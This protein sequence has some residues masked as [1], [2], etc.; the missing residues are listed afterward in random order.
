VVKEA[1][2]AGHDGNIWA[3]SPGMGA[4]AEELKNLRHGP[5]FF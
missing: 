1:V 2:I 4:H 3:T 5:Q